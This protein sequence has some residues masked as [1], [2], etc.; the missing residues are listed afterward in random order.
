MSDLNKNVWELNQ[1][2]DQNYAGNVDYT[3]VG[4]LFSL[5]GDNDKGVLGQNN[6]G[7]ATRKSLPVQI[8]GTT[9]QKFASG[10][11]D[12]NYHTGMIKND[13]TLWFWGANQYGIFG[14]NNTINTS[15][16]VQCPG[17]TWNSV[18]LQNIQSMAVKT[19]GTLWTW[20]RND[21]G[22]IGD[23][24]LTQRSSPTQ[25]PGT[26]EAIGGGEAVSALKA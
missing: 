5:G 12:T 25:V 17:T 19:D 2:Y 9:W 13:G 10:S 18:S 24:S 21:N 1:W 14:N 3:G 11:G 4:E 23:N 16:P 20:G 15:S 22:Q 7:D 26:W 6:E 8:P